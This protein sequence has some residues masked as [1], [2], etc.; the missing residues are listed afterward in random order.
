[1]K[2]VWLFLYRF[3]LINT[4]LTPDPWIAVVATVPLRVLANTN[5]AKFSIVYIV[6]PFV[7]TAYKRGGTHALRARGS[8]ASQIIPATN[9]AQGGQGGH[10]PA[11][12]ACGLAPP[13]ALQDPLGPPI[14]PIFGHLGHS[15]AL[16]D[17][18]RPP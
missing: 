3:F 15:G 17:P 6:Y 13:G 8:E 11:P 18:A 7:F 16:R 1:M 4:K 9:S 12:L 2:L 10:R 14:W 5:G